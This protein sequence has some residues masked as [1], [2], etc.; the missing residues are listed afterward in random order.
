MGNAKSKDILLITGGFS[1]SALMLTVIQAPFE[2]GFLAWVCLVPFMLVCRPE[3]SVWRLVWTSYIVSSLYWLGNLYWIGLV[4]VPAYVVFSMAQGLYWPILAVSVRFV[5]Q[6]HPGGLMYAA[7]LLFVGAEAWQGIIYT[8]FGWRLLAH[9][10]WT[11]LPFIQ[12]ADVFGQLGISVV[13]AL[14]NGFVAELILAIYNGLLRNRAIFVKAAFAAAVVAA[15]LVYGFHRLGETREHVTKGPL[16]GSV[17]PNIPSDIKE[18]SESGD[19]ILDDLLT[20]S[21][22]A[23]DAGAVLV[24]WPETIVLSSLNRG[25]VDLCRENTRPKVYDM[26]L[27]DHARDRG[28]ILLGAHSATVDS[29]T[30]TITDRYNSAFLYTPDGIQNG[31]YDKIHLVPFGEYLPFRETVPFVYNLILKLSPYDYDYNLTKG[32]DYTT[33]EMIDQT[34]TY[35]FGVLICYEDTDPTVTRKMVVSDGIKKA[36]WLV[37]ISNDG[38]YVRWKDGKVLPSV[39][40]PQRTVIAAFRAVENR[41]SIIRSVN[42]GISCVIDST[43]RIR[44]GYVNGTLPQAAMDRQGVEG[45]F[46][47]YIDIDNRTTLFSRHG[48]WL[49]FVCGSAVAVVAI[50]AISAAVAGR[51]NSRGVREKSVHRT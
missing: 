3:T 36:D 15:T 14:V 10:Q 25:Y 40:L 23:L 4:T 2:G 11:N 46:A 28:Y 29:R 20:M 6:K 31:R 39:E 34:H 17:Q 13:I 5:R 51:G 47:D 21:N 30:L 42:T 50:W 44:D 7:P 45:W 19:A 8:G 18:L 26:V 1:A 38:W 37:N 9:S 48:R 16:L 27:A 33:F 49:D 24:A 41:V 32:T 35:R 22:G 43:G 12:I